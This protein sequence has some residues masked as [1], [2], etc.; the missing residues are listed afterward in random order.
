MKKNL[1]SIVALLLCSLTTW[2]QETTPVIK[3]HSSATASLSLSVTPASGATVKVDWGDGNQVAGTPN[4]SQTVYTFSGTRTGE[5]ITLHG[6]IRT[7]D[8]SSEYGTKNDITALEIT[9]QTALEKI[10]ARGNAI[11]TPSI[12]LVHPTCRS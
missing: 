10:E 2:A 6:A 3:L 9:G 1:L 5:V 7:I 12:S 4:W 11:A 8:M